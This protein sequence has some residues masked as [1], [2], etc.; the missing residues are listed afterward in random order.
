[1]PCC[2]QNDNINALITDQGKTDKVSWETA[3][4]KAYTAIATTINSIQRTCIFKNWAITQIW[5]QTGQ[6]C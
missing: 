5:H 4:L 3:S 1:M 6:N 2:K